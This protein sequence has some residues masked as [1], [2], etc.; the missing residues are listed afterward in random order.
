M[1][2]QIDSDS[3]GVGDWCDNCPYIAN[4]GQGDK[5]GDGIGEACYLEVC[6]PALSEWLIYGN[7]GEGRIATVKPEGI[8][9]TV[10]WG[11][12]NV[13]EVFTRILGE[14][15]YELKDHLGNVR[16]VIS[17][18]KLNGDGDQGGQG[19]RAGQAPYMADMRAYNN[20]YPGGMLQPERHWSI[21]DY[22][23]KHQGQESDPEIYGEGNSYA[24]RHRM[25]DPRVIRFWSVDPLAPSYP[26]WSSYA[27]SQN[28]LIDGIELEGLEWR[29]TK[30]KEGNIMNY[31]WV[32]FNDDGSVPEGT[33]REG[34]LRESLGSTAGIITHYFGV[35]DNNQPLEEY[36]DFPNWIP[37][38]ESDLGLHEVNDKSEVAKYTTYSGLNSDAGTFTFSDGVGGV[39]PWCGC[40]VNYHLEESGYPGPEVNA[41][42][43]EN[44]NGTWR[45]WNSGTKIEKPT[46]GAI[47]TLGDAHMGIVVGMSGDNILI[48]G[49]NQGNKVSVISRSVESDYQFF[50]PKDYDPSPLDSDKEYLQNTNTSPV[51]NANSVR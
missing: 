40:F 3:D 13:V 32:G 43:V 42:A 20:Y 38:A 11:D 28:R 8:G 17:D 49:G 16:V 9:R 31:T 41:A 34:Q 12:T 30:D 19:G 22:R 29:P 10:G 47:V 33:V 4:P 46:Y 45:T 39:H 44:W 25:S 1:D 36:Y 35:D 37:S 48:L 51:E 26:G 14:K 21:K 15:E 27:F 6:G 18:V 50:L 5:N 2:R 24:Y 23:Y 7:G